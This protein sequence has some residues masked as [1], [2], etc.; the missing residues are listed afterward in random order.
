MGLLDFGA[1]L[2]GGSQADALDDQTKREAFSQSMLQL[3][4]GINPYGG[5]LLGDVARGLAGGR[6]VFGN[7]AEQQ[8]VQNMDYGQLSEYWAQRGDPEK[9]AQY[10]QLASAESAKG[11]GSRAASYL[12]QSQQ[13][14]LGAAGAPNAGQESFQQ[15]PSAAF[16]N[17]ARQAFIAGDIAS[18]NAL[19]AQAKAFRDMRDKLESQ[20][21]GGEA[22]FIN[23]Y[24]G[25]VVSKFAK[26][27]TPDAKLGSRTT[28]RGQD[29]SASTA[30]RGQDISAMTAALGQNLALGADAR[31]IEAESTKNKKQAAKAIELVNTAD[32]LISGAT[33]SGIG[34]AID[35]GAGLVGK[36]T[37]GA[38]N[39]AS[40]KGLEA[41]LVLN[42]PRLE[43]PQSNLDQ[44]LYREAAGQIGNP[45]V[46]NETKKAALRTIK[47]VLARNAGE[48]APKEPA[49]PTKPSAS[50]AGWEIVN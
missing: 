40:L 1:K 12:N 43:G 36:S 32:T 7:A 41:N 47:D 26:S 3:A 15:D 20:D 33:G 28:I 22:A 31:K 50:K 6:Q 10:A 44:Q 29:I 37:E 38:K 9:A 34:A 19:L 46:P 11:A 49:K 25:K 8:A 45:M 30:R 39:I 35:F 14:S 5:N 24:T 2:V 17:A 48:F 4:A 18:G 13:Q 27:E 16:A 21:L 23:P 42:M